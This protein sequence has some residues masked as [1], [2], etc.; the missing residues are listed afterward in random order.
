[1]HPQ[2]RV[3]ATSKPDTPK[4]CPYVPDTRPSPASPIDPSPACVAPK[5]MGH[6]KSPT[7]PLEPAP[8]PVAVCNDPKS[9]IQIPEN[10]TSAN[11]NWSIAVKICFHL[12][13]SAQFLPNLGVVP[14]HA[15]PIPLHRVAKT[16]PLRGFCCYESSVAFD[17][18][19]H[20]FPQ[21]HPTGFSLQQKPKTYTPWFGRATAFF[22]ISTGCCTSKRV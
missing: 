14:S 3:P 1:M 15:S 5:S 7:V 12:P 17:T 10:Q 13:C 8:D 9:R 2:F 4:P 19:S 22:A 21:I 18:H 16:P 11:G 20:H 6:S